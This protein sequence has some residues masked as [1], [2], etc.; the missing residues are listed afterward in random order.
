MHDIDASRM[1]R[2][3]RCSEVERQQQEIGQ[4]LLAASQEHES[5]LTERPAGMTSRIFY[6][7]AEMIGTMFANLHS[8][9]RHD[10]CLNTPM[11]LQ[12]FGPNW[13]S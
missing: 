10:E 6:H 1:L 4:A 7:K 11:H 3:L 2:R 13:Q 12:A 9:Q 5:K 8:L